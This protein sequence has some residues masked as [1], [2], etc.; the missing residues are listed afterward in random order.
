MIMVSLEWLAR[1]SKA[2]SAT[3]PAAAS[4]PFAPGRFEAPWHAELFALTVALSEAGRFA[5]PEWAETFGAALARH[6]AEKAL[7]GG[8]DYF[9]A[10]LDALETLLQAKGFAGVEETETMRAAWEEAYLST[11]HGAPVTLRG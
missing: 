6:G 5:W 10:W 11:P 2:S 7:D 4:D 1:S 3:G 9:R 8:E